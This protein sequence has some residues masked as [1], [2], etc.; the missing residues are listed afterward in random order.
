MIG[1]SMNLLAVAIGGGL[2]GLCRYAITV[3]C[4]QGPLS[5]SIA[6]IGD[7]VGGGASLATTLANLSGCLLLGVLYQWG[8]SLAAVGQSPLSPRTMLALR[9]GVL[10]S[11]TTFS[12][13]IGD[14]A[15]LGSEDRAVASLTLISVNLFGG[16]AIF[17]LS[18]AAVKGLLS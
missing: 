9:V 18:A 6:G 3:L 14:A 7:V 17:L 4:T 2:G 11:L 1:W 15:V 5:H 13:L 8:E 10:G 16:W 12:T